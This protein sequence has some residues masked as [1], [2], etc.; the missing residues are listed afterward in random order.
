MPQTRTAANSKTSG[1]TAPSRT[2]SARHA[3][4]VGLRPGRFRRIMG[5]EHLWMLKAAVEEPAK[6]RSLV[7]QAAAG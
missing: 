4:A 2:R 7:Q 5:H 1:P 6:D 3:E